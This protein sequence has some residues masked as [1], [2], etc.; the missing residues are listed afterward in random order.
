MLDISS[1][2]S[3]KFWE[4]L[5]TRRQDITRGTRSQ[6]HFLSFFFLSIM[7]MKNIV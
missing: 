1:S 7:K 5:E 2:D 3:G 6:G 4:V